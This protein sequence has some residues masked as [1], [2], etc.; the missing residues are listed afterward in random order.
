MSDV[1]TS[2][3]AAPIAPVDPLKLAAEHEA[4]GRLDEAQAALDGFLADHPEH[5]EALHLK[6]VVAVRQGDTPAGAA[7]MERSVAAGPVRPYYLRN[8]CEVYRTL[9]RYD[10][11]LEA[12]LKAVAGDT[13]DPIAHA[14]LS[15]LH[16]ERG[17][18]TD[19]VISAE[20][21][22]R[23]N[24][25][26]PGAH[27]GLAEALLLR[28]DM[29]RGWEE[30]EWRFRMP[31]VPPLMP[32]NDVPQWDGKPLESGRLMLIADQG[33][34]DGIQ[35]ARYI[36]WAI[37][38]C[39]EVV[40][41]CSKE[42]Q[43]LI[44]QVPG[45]SALFDRWEAAPA[46]AAFIPLSG[47]PRLHG[48]RVDTVPWD[49]PYLKA[50]PGKATR[51][52]ERLDQLVAPGH[53][54]IGLVWAGR[55]THKND[56]NRSVAL[57]ALAP[58]TELAGITFVSLQKGPGQTQVGGYFGRAP[59]INVGPEIDDFA[60]SLAV[61]DGLERVVTVDT[62]IGHLAGAMGKSAFLMLPYA[63]DWRWLEK[64]ADTPWYPSV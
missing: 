59:L 1:A 56:R 62:A 54:R 7:L 57:T 24:P 51:W 18:P 35:F 46:C 2:P 32:K 21:A 17:A 36:P 23:I 43:P 14:N 3:A 47:L 16:Y 34:G 37:E 26:M 38:R 55:P 40:V 58:L 11:A 29:A 33:F 53:R 28:G 20:R 30:Y 4:A 60:D 8:L 45:I 13:N 5:A 27:F 63:P 52:R 44:G 22:L 48:T 25:N 6:G 41:A 39:A 61:I 49:G 31:G 10:E 64:R 19:A 12:G 42:L 9:G 15:V 50:D